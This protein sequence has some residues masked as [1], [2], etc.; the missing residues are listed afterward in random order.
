MKHRAARKKN[1]MMRISASVSAL[2]IASIV[3]TTSVMS[4]ESSFNSSTNSKITGNADILSAPR[5]LI[6]TNTRVGETDLSWTASVSSYAT[7]YKIYRAV[8]SSGPWTQIGT[9]SGSSNVSYID[10]TSGLFKWSYKVET[11]YGNWS[12]M[13]PIV[14]GPEAA[15]LTFTESFTGSGDLNN[16]MTQNGA[17]KWEVWRGSV[18]VGNFS[19]YG[20]GAQGSGFSTTAG[21]AMAV[22]KTSAHDGWIN[23]S[24]LSG[25]EGAI[26]RAKDANN[27]VYVGGK[28]TGTPGDGSFEIAIVKDGVRRVIND[29]YVVERPMGRVNVT[30]NIR[31]EGDVVLARFD[32]NRNDIESGNL[33]VAI[34]DTGLMA[35]EPNAVYFG[36]GFTKKSLLPGYN[37]NATTQEIQ[38]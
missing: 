14:N 28:L 10:K 4:T 29:G 18:Q 6:V 17:S 7:G 16:R 32:A 30:A 34:R 37:F 9:V 20:Q 12:A 2:A 22:M 26:L 38:R 8:T 15:G 23:I 36:I 33:H 11:I 21:P 24:N 13:S 3:L 27:Y 25:G 31:V 35:T 5:N 1:L 19:G